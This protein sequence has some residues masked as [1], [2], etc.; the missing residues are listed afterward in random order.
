MSLL[1]LLLILF[2][3][4]ALLSLLE[5]VMIQAF[6][7]TCIFAWLNLR[8]MSSKTLPTEARYGRGMQLWGWLGLGYLFGFALLFIYWY[9]YIK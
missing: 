4:G 6:M 5:L 8:L 7:T 9:C 3:K 2:F 1:A